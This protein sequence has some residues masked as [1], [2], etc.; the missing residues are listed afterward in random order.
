LFVE[1][2][3]ESEVELIGLD[4]AVIYQDSISSHHQF[5]VSHLQS[6]IYFVRIG[7]SNYKWTKL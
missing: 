6:G 2:D 4:G 7:G 1:T 3:K 5:D